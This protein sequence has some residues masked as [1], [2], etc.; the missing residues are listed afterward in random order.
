ML[1]RLGSATHISNTTAAIRKLELDPAATMD[2]L[3]ELYDRGKIKLTRSPD[4]T[5]LVRN[6]DLRDEEAQHI[7]D[8]VAEKVQKRLRG[9]GEFVA[10]IESGVAP[11][12]ALKSRFVG[13]S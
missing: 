13:W 8:D 3:F 6:R 4:K 12:L 1:Q 10:L 9:F 2:V 7:V 5:F 11:S